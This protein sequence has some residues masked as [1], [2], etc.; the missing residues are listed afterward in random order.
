MVEEGVWSSVL[1]RALLK[2]RREKLY[3][4]KFLKERDRGYFLGFLCLIWR[5]TS[6]PK[7]LSE[8]STHNFTFRLFPLFN[9][10]FKLLYG[11]LDELEFLHIWCPWKDLDF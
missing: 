5:T 3:L 2:K 11:G 6:H 4:K 1:R 8:H 10:I 7:C 9:P